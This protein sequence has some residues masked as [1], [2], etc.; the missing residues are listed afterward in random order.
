M[1]EQQHPKLT[2]LFR[3]KFV[4]KFDEEEP[5]WPYSIYGKFCSVVSSVK[6]FFP[7]GP[8]KQDL[9]DYEYAS[10]LDRLI[11]DTGN[12]IAGWD[13]EE[14]VDDRSVLSYRCTTEYYND[15]DVEYVRDSWLWDIRKSAG[16]EITDNIDASG[17]IIVD[18]NCMA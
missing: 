11:Y 6:E 15:A 5:V 17:E 10:S 16:V 2:V 9:R 8:S 7:S 12:C 3:K 4:S 1:T 18:F 13:R 14:I